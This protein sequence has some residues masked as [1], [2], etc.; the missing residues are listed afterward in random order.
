MHVF[1]LVYPGM[2]LVWIT[3]CFTVGF[4][5]PCCHCCMFGCSWNPHC[6]GMT[7]YLPQPESRG[8]FYITSKTASEEKNGT[9]PDSFSFSSLLFQHCLSSLKPFV[10]HR[11]WAPCCGG[12]YGYHHSEHFVSNY[13]TFN[14]ICSSFKAV[15]H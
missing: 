12:W 13:V 1:K 6:H 3:P 8:K 5:W 15:Q 14:L 11:D 7:G 2:S 10:H 4:N 9:S